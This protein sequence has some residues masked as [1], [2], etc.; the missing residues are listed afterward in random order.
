MPTLLLPGEGG[1]SHFCSATSWA[2]DQRELSC[3]TILQFAVGQHSRNPNPEFTAASYPALT[4]ENS[5]AFRHPC[6]FF[7]PADPDT[8]LSH[9]GFHPVSPPKHLSGRNIS[10][11]SRFLKVPILCSTAIS[12][13]GSQLMEAPSAKG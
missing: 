7:N 6:S 5:A 9:L 10:H 3:P 4:L 13:S 2:P 1:R 11:Q 8:M 12:L